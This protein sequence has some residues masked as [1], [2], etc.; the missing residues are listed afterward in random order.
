MPRSTAFAEALPEVDRMARSLWK[1]IRYNAQAQIDADDLAQEGRRALWELAQV[2]DPESG[3]LWC[4]YTSRGVRWAMVDLIRQACRVQRIPL[5]EIEEPAAEE[6]DPG[7]ALHTR[8]V[9]AASADP[10][11]QI[12]EAEGYGASQSLTVAE[13]ATLRGITPRAVTAKLRSG[14]IRG[15]RRGRR[16]A[17]PAYAAAG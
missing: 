11:P 12:A 13:V 2:R 5:D 7:L 14:V 4:S 1:A 10:L 16:W 17:I 6:R 3:P 15:V 8:R 9:V